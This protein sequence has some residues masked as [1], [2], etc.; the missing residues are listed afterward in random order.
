MVGVGGLR[1]NGR[2][3]KKIW[4]ALVGEGLN[5]DVRLVEG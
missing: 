3:V 5:E 2:T 4:N 1:G